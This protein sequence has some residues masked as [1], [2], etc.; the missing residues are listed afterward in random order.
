[1]ISICKFISFSIDCVVDFESG[2]WPSYTSRFYNFPD[3]QFFNPAQTG[4]L[5]CLSLPWATLDLG[6]PAGFGFN[7]KI[8]SV[9]AGGIDC[10]VA[11]K[12]KIEDYFGN[13]AFR[14]LATLIVRLNYFDMTSPFI[15]RVTF[16]AYIMSK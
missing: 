16:W 4:P 13:D 6:N 8:T 14:V 12:N 11:A 5:C 9:P 15:I 1:M 3:D 2:T 10:H 7:L